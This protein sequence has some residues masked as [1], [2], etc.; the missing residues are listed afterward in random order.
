M[1]YIIFVL[2]IFISSAAL[3][4]FLKHRKQFAGTKVFSAVATSL[5]IALSLEVFTFNFPA[6]EL[7]D[8]SAQKQNYQWTAL[9]NDQPKNSQVTVTS[10]GDDKIIKYEINQIETCVRHIDIRIDTDRESVPVKLEFSDDAN[11]QLRRVESDGIEIVP[12]VKGTTHLMPDFSG[13]VHGLCFTF[14]VDQMDT[15]GSIQIILNEKPG[16][17]FHP[18]RAEI[19]FFITLLILMIVLYSK[20][21]ENLFEDSGDRQRYYSI[22]GFHIKKKITK[23]LMIAFVLCE[24]VFMIN[25][26]HAAKREMPLFMK[27]GA[28][29]DI[30]QNL[31]LALSRGKVDLNG[32]NPDTVDQE[33]EGILQLQ[34]LEHPYQWNARDGI[35]YKWD[36]SFYKGKYYCYFGIVPALL[37]YLPVY[38]LTGKLLNTKVVAF[39]F[40]LLSAIFMAKLAYDIA[41]KR[42]KKINSWVVVCAALG[43][44]NASMLVFNVVNNN[45][46]EAARISALMFALLG[47]DLLYN[48]FL[49][50]KTSGVR[51]FFGALC[52]AL[53]VGCRPNYILASFP[54]LILVLNG[55]RNAGEDGKRTIG[56][57]A[58]GKERIAHYFKC[59]FRREHYPA[60]VAFIIPY[61]VIGLGLMYYN[62]IRFGSIFEFGA[63]YQLTVY[64]VNTYSLGNLAKLPTAVYESFFQMPEVAGVFPFLTPLFHQNDYLGYIYKLPTIGLLFFPMMWLLFLLPWSLK[65]GIKKMRDRG[66]VVSALVMGILSCYITT[67]MGG[68]STGYSMD[69]SWLLYIPVIYILYDLYDAAKAKKIT[70]YVLAL[71]LLMTAVTVFVTVLLCLSDGIGALRTE[72]PEFFYKIKD[73][74]IFWN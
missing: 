29:P 21:E 46:Y 50:K 63:R 61:V 51:L 9:G 2:G 6:Y 58:A 35:N 64:D 26:A 17:V 24:L 67:V 38:L 40:V 5:V 74:M 30:Y 65:R 8:S 48:A 31:T 49:N 27:D 12:K 66:F 36:Y 53:A 4:F 73:M 7:S 70:K 52:M 42:K 56:K 23:F 71:I 22:F 19:V 18:V 33:N 62:F 32:L 1:Q 3:V 15:I 54:A 37:C 20:K 25:I 43:F 11:E 68:V 10:I 41:R 39:L 47:L 69:F 60:I 59:I 44:I 57:T 16:F 14:T 34:K 45:F 28:A 13:T 72:N 55:F